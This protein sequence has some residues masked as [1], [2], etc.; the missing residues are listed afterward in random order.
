M[1]LNLP[2]A[3]CHIARVG[4]CIKSGWEGGL[5]AAEILLYFVYFQSMLWEKSLQFIG[6]SMY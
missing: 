3:W 5:R 2:F 1:E 6:R 4:T